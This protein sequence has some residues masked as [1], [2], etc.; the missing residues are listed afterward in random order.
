MTER[1]TRAVCPLPYKLDG[2]LPTADNRRCDGKGGVMGAFTHFY[3]Q[4]YA[5]HL[6]RTDVDYNN[7]QIRTVL[8]SYYSISIAISNSSK[9]L[10]EILEKTISEV[11]L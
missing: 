4:Y 6:M 2:Q 3:H 10:A 7:I 8:N 5:E 11:D 9:V 1:E